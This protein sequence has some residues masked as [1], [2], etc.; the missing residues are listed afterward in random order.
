MSSEQAL[1]PGFYYIRTTEST[2]R[3]I[4]NP[5]TDNQQ[6]YVANSSTDLSHQVSWLYC[7]VI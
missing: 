2:P 4:I 3:D 7:T 1:A 5:G 6:L